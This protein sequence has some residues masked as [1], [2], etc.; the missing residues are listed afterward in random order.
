MQ[1]RGVQ[2]GLALAFVCAGITSTL[3]DP[4]GVWLAKD[5]ARVRVANCG[6]ALCGTVI[7]TNPAKDAATGRP[8]VDSKNPD[9]SKTTRPLVGMTVFISMRP[10]GPGRWSGHHYDSDRGVTVD[11]HLI[12]RDTK[13]L[14]IEGCVGAMCGGEEMT[15]VR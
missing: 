15:R 5:G 6:A 7:S 13:T 14:R 3:A 8:F 1:G 11:G 2:F 10:S 9:A 12:E 4:R